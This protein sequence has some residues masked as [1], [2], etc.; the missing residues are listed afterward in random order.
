M[1][2]AGRVQEFA[3][4][5]LDAPVDSDYAQ[6][7]ISACT[8]DAR[9]ARAVAVVVEEVGNRGSLGVSKRRTPL[10][11]SAVFDL[12]AQLVSS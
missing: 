9:N 1:P 12:R 3:R 5:Q 7:V 2:A 8:F 4:H 11:G 6:A 10:S